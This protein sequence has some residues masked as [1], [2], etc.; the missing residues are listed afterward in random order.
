[1]GL[2]RPNGR[3]CNLT[4]RCTHVHVIRSLVIHGGPT[5]NS[6]PDDPQNPR[7]ITNTELGNVYYKIQYNTPYN[8]RS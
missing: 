7:R 1:M 5:R 6:S 4:C 3:E 2:L 8:I